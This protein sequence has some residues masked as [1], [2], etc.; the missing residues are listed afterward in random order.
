MSRDE[1]GLTAA[2]SGPN[3]QQEI[4]Y[5]IFTKDLLEAKALLAEL[6]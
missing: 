3:N 5:L 1:A 6:G 4:S 2:P